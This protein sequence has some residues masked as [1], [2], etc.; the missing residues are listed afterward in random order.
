D[1]A[2]NET[3][4]PA[5]STLQKRPLAAARIELVVEMEFEQL[6]REFE[7]GFCRLLTK[8]AEVTG[9]IRVIF[10]QKGSVVLT[11]EASQEDAERIIRAA[12]N[13]DLDEMGVMSA[14]LLTTHGPKG[15]FV[16]EARASLDAVH[17]H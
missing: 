2:L 17:F 15:A 12:E 7:A 6:T 9:D 14:R 16:G 3:G 1:D 8:L 11:L 5:D 13:G 10:R 4:R